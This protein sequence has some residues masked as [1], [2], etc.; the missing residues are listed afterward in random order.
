MIDDRV[1]HSTGELP[2]VVGFDK[3][4][5]HGSHVEMVKVNFVC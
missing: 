2:L 1:L 5:L 3:N 4:G